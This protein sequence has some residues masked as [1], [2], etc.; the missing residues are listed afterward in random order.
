MRRTR[1]SPYEHHSA[2]MLII[3]SRGFVEAVVQRCSV[4]KVF[5]KILQNSHEKTCARV[6]LLIKLQAEVQL[7]QKR[8]PGTG[9]FL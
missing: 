9:V 6:S 4:K 8:D 2:N 1:H 5:L 3:R 7:Y